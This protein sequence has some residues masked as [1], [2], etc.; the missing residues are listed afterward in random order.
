MRMLQGSKWDAEEIRNFCF[1][2]TWKNKRIS[3]KSNLAEKSKSLLLRSPA[4]T[5]M[6]VVLYRYSDK[7]LYLEK[8]FCQNWALEQGREL[9]RGLRILAKRNQAESIVLE[10]EMESSA[11][12]FYKACGF[13]LKAFQ[14]APPSIA[15]SEKIGFW[16]LPIKDPAEAS[17]EEL[18]EILQFA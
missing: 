17:I 18:S 12:A 4:G 16:S 1:P 3:Q 6:G 2:A 10:A 11:D 15:P 8:F 5:L 13:R 14:A 9:V 7:C